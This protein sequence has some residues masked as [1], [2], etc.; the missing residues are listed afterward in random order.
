MN[1]IVVRKRDD[2][3]GKL[4]Y[5]SDMRYF[6]FPLTVLAIVACSQPASPSL[7]GPQDMFFAEL[8][9]LC[10]QAFNGKL[11]SADVADAEFGKQSMVMHVRE[12]SPREILIPFFVGDD[13]SRTWVITRQ[14][15]GLRLKHDHRH[16][17]GS[18]DAVTQYGGDTDMPGSAARQSFPVD[19][20]SIAMFEREGLAASVDN[21]WNVEVRDGLFAYELTRPNRLFRVEFDTGTPITPP[22]APWGFE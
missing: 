12:C 10:G 20:F 8:T 22:P 2:L 5:R 6:I 3:P 4:G 7:D 9:K 1:Q 19:A 15:G 18:E 14:E 13:R 17:D 16:E 21:V 11:T